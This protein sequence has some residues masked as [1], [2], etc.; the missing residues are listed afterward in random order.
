M[1][2][3]QCP[4]DWL[5]KLCTADY[6]DMLAVVDLRSALSSGEVN[7]LPLTASKDNDYFFIVG[8]D[9]AAL[10]PPHSA[11]SDLRKVHRALISLSFNT[12]DF[13]HDTVPIPHFVLPVGRL[14]Q[15]YTTDFLLFLF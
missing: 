4:E 7:Y 6:G 11:P 5:R 14:F 13:S 2:F 12:V 10:G 15:V 1:P 3:Y 8:S 9:P